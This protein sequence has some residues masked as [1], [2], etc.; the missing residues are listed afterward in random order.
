MQVHGAES[1]GPTLNPKVVLSEASAAS[2]HFHWPEVTRDSQIPTQAQIWS[3]DTSLISVLVVGNGQPQSSTNEEQRTV[4]LF[5]ARKLLFNE[6][7]LHDKRFYYLAW[8]T[9]VA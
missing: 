6:S 2:R 9:V 4:Y 5:F 8:R 1:R 3:L 7:R